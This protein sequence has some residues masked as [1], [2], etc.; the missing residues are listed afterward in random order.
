MVAEETGGPTFR[1]LTET[2]LLSSFPLV[3][4]FRCYFDSSVRQ[5]SVVT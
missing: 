5:S 1:P 2:T 3:D 4:S